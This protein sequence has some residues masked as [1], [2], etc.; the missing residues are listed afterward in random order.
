VG[1]P[2]GLC[3]ALPLSEGSPLAGARLRLAPLR[4]AWA[5]ELHRLMTHPKVRRFLWDNRIIARAETEEIIAESRRSFH[6][7][8][9]GI[10]GIFPREDG[11]M[12]GFAGLWHFFGETE[13]QLLFALHP[14]YWGRG[15]A[16]EAARVVM[17]YAYDTL[18]FKKIRASCDVPNSA[19][20]RVLER[21]GMER[22]HTA[23]VSGKALAFFEGRFPSCTSPKKCFPSQVRMIMK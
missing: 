8:G 18:D 2:Y 10:W 14:A 21:L 15:F 5:R 22:V 23:Y 17:D 16:V 4:P 3:Y 20:T 7:N 12:L 6:K 11:P 1:D 19:S 9:Y 13:P